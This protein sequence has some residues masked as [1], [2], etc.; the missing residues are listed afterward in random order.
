MFYTAMLLDPIVIRIPQE[1]R[2]GTP[3]SGH[4][5]VWL[6][7]HSE[8]P[9]YTISGGPFRTHKTLWPLWEIRTNQMLY[10]LRRL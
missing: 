6:S 9:S 3:Q 8:E 10:L 4:V 2:H 1:R 7:R 5:F